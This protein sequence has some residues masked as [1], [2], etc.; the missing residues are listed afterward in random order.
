M[1]VKKKPKQW[2]KVIG[3]LNHAVLYIHRILI[4]LLSV[5]PESLVVVSEISGKMAIKCTMDMALVIF[6]IF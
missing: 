2:F 3:V 5:S 4:D 1:F 6:L